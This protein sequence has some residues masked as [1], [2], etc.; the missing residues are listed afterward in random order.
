MEFTPARRENRRLIIAVSKVGRMRC[1]FATKDNKTVRWSLMVGHG[2]GTYRF[3][4]LGFAVVV[5]PYS[6]VW[7]YK[8]LR[9][10][11]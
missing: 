9:E 3:H 6:R 7:N 4:G 1:T 2:V 5:G 10:G 11:V 8:E